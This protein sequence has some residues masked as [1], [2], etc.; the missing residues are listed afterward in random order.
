VAPP[1]RAQA[2]G[3]IRA[4]NQRNHQAAAALSFPIWAAWVNTSPRAQQ[5]E[6]LGGQEGQI[7]SRWRHP[8]GLLQA[9]PSPTGAHR[10]LMARQP[11]G[12][13]SAPTPRG[14]SRLGRSSSLPWPRPSPTAKPAPS[15]ARRQNSR[16]SRAAIKAQTRWRESLARRQTPRLTCPKGMRMTGAGQLQHCRSWQRRRPWAVV[17]DHGLPAAANRNQPRSSR[18]K[19]EAAQAQTPNTSTYEKRHPPPATSVEM[20][21]DPRHGRERRPRPAKQTEH[22]EHLCFKRS[23]RIGA[24]AEFAGAGQASSLRGCALSAKL[25]RVR[26]EPSAAPPLRACSQR[27]R[28]AASNPRLANG[29]PQRNGAGPNRTGPPPAPY[30]AGHAG[31]QSR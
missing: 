25:Q 11:T 30:V 3:L 29:P 6:P 5:P 21:T 26:R 28:R 14:A 18:R 23:D 22:A 15:A 17:T 9:A 24:V 31:G 16:P 27:K 12:R 10:C 7:P 19:C 2:L 13:G 1:D 8:S 20:K 4:C